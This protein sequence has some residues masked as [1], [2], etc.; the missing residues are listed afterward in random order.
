MGWMGG[1]FTGN[2]ATLNSDLATAG[3]VSKQGMG[4]GQFGTK[5]GEGAMNRANDFYGTMLSGD[6]R[7]EAKLLTPQI[8]TAQ[9]QGQEQL[10]KT[11]QFGNRSGGTNASGQMNMDNSRANIDNMI[12]QLT[13]QA[14]AGEASLGENAVNEGIQGYQLGLQGAEAQSSMASQ[15]QKNQGHSIG[16]QMIK[17]QTGTF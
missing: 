8:D 9:K 10:E 5:L 4:I 12:A 17:Q 7:A 3:N 15:I 2:N 11:S 13:G 14:A 16:G 1:M 6:P